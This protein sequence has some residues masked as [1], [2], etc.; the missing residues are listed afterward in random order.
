[1]LKAF[2]RPTRSI[3]ALT[4]AAA[5][6]GAC[7]KDKPEAATSAA[8]QAETAPPQAAAPAVAPAAAAPT[9][10]AAKS[11]VLAVADLDLYEQGL[12]KENA[13]VK[14]AMERARSASSDAEKLDAK[15]A[16]TPRQTETEAAGALGVD[17]GHYRKVKEAVNQILGTQEMNAALE[18]QFQGMNS[19][20]LSEELKASIEQN[21]ANLRA[22]LADPFKDITPEVVSEF[23]AR[24]ARLAALRAENIGLLMNAGR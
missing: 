21:K 5:L 7:G 8:A 3:V 6:L 2:H 14:A 23:Q 22:S 16:A 18:K 13:L 20:G 4:L 24:Q 12:D 15:F 1:M 17:A 19:E 10:V 11:F 9:P